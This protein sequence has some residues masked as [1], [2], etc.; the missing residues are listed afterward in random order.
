MV[1][2]YNNITPYRHLNTTQFT[3]QYY[4]LLF[5]TCSDMGYKKNVSNCIA[6][7]KRQVLKHFER[8]RH[9]NLIS[10]LE[11]HYQAILLLSSRTTLVCLGKQNSSVSFFFKR[12]LKYTRSVSYENIVA[13]DTAGMF[14]KLS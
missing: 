1:S 6:F 8:K 12:G 3:T 11:I 2:T 5:L 13:Y 7:L 9:F 4:M 14:M 10:L